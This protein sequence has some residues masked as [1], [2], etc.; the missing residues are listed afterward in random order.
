MAGSEVADSV[1]VRLGVR[2]VLGGGL[3]F[4]AQ[5]PWGEGIEI[6]CLGVLTSKYTNCLLV[7]T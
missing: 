2:L 6:S 1:S 3:C 7:L 5:W 4:L